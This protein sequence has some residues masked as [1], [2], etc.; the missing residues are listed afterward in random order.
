MNQGFSCGYVFDVVLLACY[1]IHH[2]MHKFSFRI[3]T[4]L[5]LSITSF[6][7]ALSPVM[8]VEE[9]ATRCVTA[10]TQSMHASTVQ[11]MEKDIA[12][13]AADPLASDAIQKYRE[14]INTAWAAMEEPYCGYGT[15][16]AASAK[17]SYTKSA[18]RARGA[19]L[20]AVKNLIKTKTVVTHVSEPPAV[21]MKKIEHEPAVIALSAARV[22]PGLRRGMRSSAVMD[23]QQKLAEFFN[24]P[25]EDLATGYFGSKT[26]NLVI[27]F[28]LKKKIIS[29]ETQEGAGRVGPKTAAAL[30]AL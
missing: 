22:V 7:L 11:R 18:D 4:T 29:S 20:E 27:K 15:Y 10:T 1:S 17:K 2:L 13:Y 9:P 14:N 12:P 25:E 30:N 23:V 28:Q 3:I 16:G 26:E 19:F 24:L 8:A 5:A 21:A 6:S